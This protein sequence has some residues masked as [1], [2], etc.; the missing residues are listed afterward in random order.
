MNIQPA[1][2]KK[3][4]DTHSPVVKAQLRT[5]AS[6]RVIESRHRC[7]PK[8]HCQSWTFFFRRLQRS[9]NN[10]GKKKQGKIGCTPINVPMVFSW[11]SRMG[12]LGII[13]LYRAYI[14]ISHRGTLVGVH[15]TI[16]WLNKPIW[17]IW[18]SNW[19]ITPWF[20]DK[21]KHIW[22][23]RL[24]NRRFKLYFLS[25]DIQIPS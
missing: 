13:T 16:P 8:Q 7:K 23:N 5:L 21:K 22:N 10:L 3:K 17:K 15:P 19:M 25:L 14:G 11:C 24:A 1:H 6:C 4:H 12:F 20:G 18:S 2:L 9:I